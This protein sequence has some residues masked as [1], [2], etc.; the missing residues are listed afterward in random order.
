MVIDGLNQSIH[1]CVYRYESTEIHDRLFIRVTSTTI[2]CR[3]ICTK[4]V[5][6]VPY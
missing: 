5:E 3:D 6:L 2:S 4:R 1:C